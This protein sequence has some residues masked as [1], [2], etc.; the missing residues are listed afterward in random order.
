M[1]SQMSMTLNQLMVRAEYVLLTG[2]SYRI[3]REPKKKEIIMI[4]IESKFPS[5]NLDLKKDKSPLK[6]SHPYATRS[7]GEPPTLS[8]STTAGMGSGGLRKAHTQSVTFCSK[9][10]GKP[11]WI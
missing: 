2:I 7:K 8:L 3:L 5:Y 11:F 6:T 9:C 10:L 4:L 1:Q